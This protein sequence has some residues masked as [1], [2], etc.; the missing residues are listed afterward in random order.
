MNAKSLLVLGLLA[1]MGAAWGQ[2]ACPQGVPPGD[3]RC[4][5]SSGVSGIDMTPPPSGPRWQLTWGAIASDS[6]TG[7]VGTTTGHFSRGKAKREALSKCAALGARSCKLDLAYK[8]QCAV[9]AW[10]SENGKSVAGPAITRGGPSIE[11]ASQGALASCKK[12]RSGGE[13]TIVYSDCTSPV[14]V[15]N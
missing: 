10:A 9:I 14:L 4:G 6:T 15:N 11:D 5:P 13:C 7:D 3:P 2:T 1:P 8:H 12:M